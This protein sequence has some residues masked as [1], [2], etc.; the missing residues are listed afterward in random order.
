MTLKLTPILEVARK[1]LKTAG[2]KGIA[3]QASKLNNN[4]SLPQ[5][6]FSKK[7]QAALAANL[8]LKTKKPSFARVEGK[9][10]GR[11][12]GAAIAQNWYGQCL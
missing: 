3:V 11:S 8:N 2:L 5:D 4:L 9:K 10:R 1:I 7:L 6:E 12:S